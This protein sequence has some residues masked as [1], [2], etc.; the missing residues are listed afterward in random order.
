MV[1]NI[2]LD[3]FRPPRGATPRAWSQKLDKQLGFNIFSIE[4]K[5]LKK[6]RAYDQP[7]DESNKKKH[8]QGTQAW[9]GLHPQVLQTPY[10]EIIDFMSILESISPQKICDIGAGYG[11]VGFVTNA[12]FPE[13]EF[14]G[15]EVVAERAKEA[16][17]V[18]EQ[19]GLHQ[20]QVLQ[21]N[22]LDGEISLPE[23][24]LYFI[25]DF[26][27]PADLRRLLDKFDEMWFERNFFL[28]ARGK[29][30]RGIIQHKYPKFHAVNNPIHRENWS[31]YSSW[32]DIDH[33]EQRP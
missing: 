24:D 15:Y 22:I 2:N 33:L 9:I 14:L 20:C 18:F 27:D 16:N 31:M 5:L 17:R 7:A 4:Q 21:E 19:Y 25:Y 12:M 23:A 28:V 26:S 1:E 13:C 11:R 3:F 8:Y 30:I 32:I 6:Y 10:P 29:G